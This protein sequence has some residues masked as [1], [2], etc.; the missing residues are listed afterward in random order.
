MVVQFVSM[1]KGRTHRLND[2]IPSNEFRANTHNSIQQ[3]NECIFHSTSTQVFRLC[4]GGSSSHRICS[5]NEIS[6]SEKVC[7]DSDRTLSTNVRK[8]STLF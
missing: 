7:K 2:G 4:Y 8:A 6:C 1:M 5:C 3:S